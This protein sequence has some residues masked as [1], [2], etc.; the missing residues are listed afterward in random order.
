M[1]R[2]R[3]AGVAH[4]ELWC[5]YLDSQNRL[6]SWRKLTEGVGGRVYVHNA[7]VLGP[8]L[9]LKATGIILVH[10]H[11]GGSPQPSAADIDLTRAVAHA[12]RMMDIRLLDH[13]I[14]TEDDYTSLA[15]TGII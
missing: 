7:A 15:E 13:V 12:A 9:E 8:A 10:N 6:I 2:Q 5:A 3:L 1:A 14:V 4:E 11:P